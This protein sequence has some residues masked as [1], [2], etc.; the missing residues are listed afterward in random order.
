MPSRQ[1]AA[2]AHITGLDFSPITHT[3]NTYVTHGALAQ[4]SVM[5]ETLVSVKHHSPCSCAPMNRGN[6]QLANLTTVISHCV[7]PI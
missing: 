3:A 2:H 6:V 7:N 4:I 5:L 1:S